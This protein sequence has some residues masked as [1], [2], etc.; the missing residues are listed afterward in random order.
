MVIMTK[1]QQE[2]LLKSIKKGL[3]ATPAFILEQ[4]K[5]LQIEETNDGEINCLKTMIEPPP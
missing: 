3:S 2:S 4:K 5:I 1:R